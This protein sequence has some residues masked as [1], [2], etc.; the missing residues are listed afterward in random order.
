M[1]SIPRLTTL[2]LAALGALAAACHPS[3]EPLRVRTAPV[4]VPLCTDGCNGGR[5]QVTYLGVG[6]FVVRS[7][8]AALMTAPSF[9][10]PGF[11]SVTLPWGNVASKP[12]RVRDGLAQVDLAGVSAILV[13]HAHYDHLLDV[14]TVVR[15][16]LPRAR[17]YG[18]ATMA[19]ILHGDDSLR[20]WKSA[21][22]VAEWAGDAARPGTWVYLEGG[23]FRILPIRTSHAPN[24]NVG[25]SR[26]FGHTIAKGEVLQPLAALPGRAGGWKMGQP[27][28]YVID[29]VDPADST[30]PVFRI[31]YQDA[32]S[33]RQD[34]VL[35]LPA[36]DGKAVDV[37]IVCVGS[38]GNVKHYPASV[39]DAMQPRHL[40]L[41]HW[42]DFF[43]SGDAPLEVIRLTDTRALRDTLDAR[44]PGR[45]TTPAPRVPLTFLY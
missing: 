19:N 17:V 27:Y 2:A 1:P 11:W 32:A 29:A 13:G 31:F 41:G 44:M 16:R 24:L 3:P 25:R 36:P 43:R 14:P 15:Q 9:S 18:S 6:G 10:N 45:W 39:I 40:V 37:A 35:P 4:E 5:V 26:R 33:R 22:S 28:A 12:D 7:G 34:N 23:R 8:D 42:E 38:Y 21:V 30:R 20:Q